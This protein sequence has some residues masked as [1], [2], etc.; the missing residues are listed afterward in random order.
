VSGRRGAIVLNVLLFNRH[1][2]SRRAH[3][4]LWPGVLGPV[5]KAQEIVDY[6]PF[7]SLVILTGVIASFIGSW[8]RT[9]KRSWPQS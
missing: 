7:I 8:S 5:F 3:L 6:A 1:G 9:R 2:V 4:T